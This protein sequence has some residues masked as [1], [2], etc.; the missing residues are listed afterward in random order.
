MTVG[1]MKAK[2]AEYPD[3]LPVRIIWD[4]QA[5]DPGQCG[6]TVE[7]RDRLVNGDVLAIDVDGPNA[8]TPR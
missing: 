8:R 4:G 7:Q 1:E 5:T 6:W 3:V 2:L